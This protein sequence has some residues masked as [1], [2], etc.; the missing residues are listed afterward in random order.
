MPSA[1]ATFPA[2]LRPSALTVRVEKSYPSFSLKLDFQIPEAGIT[3]VF[4]PSG[5]GKTTL[6]NLVAGLERPDRGL[7]RHHERTLFDS[8]SGV[9]L[10]PERRRLGYV[11]Q[12]PLLF[13]HLTV[14]GNLRFAPRF[15]GRRGRP[16]DYDK[17]VEL[18][19]L[20]RLLGR[21]PQTLSGGESQRVAIGRALMADP[22]LLL[23]DEPLSSLD[24][25]RKDELVAHIDQ[26]PPRFGLSVLY[27]THDAAEAR[28]LADNVLPLVDGRLG[29]ETAFQPL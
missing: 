12:S 4:G 17:V 16:G 9:C 21:R 26:I 10:P 25:G 20:G 15:C 2:Q 18:L 19:G 11:F 24:Q 3:V 14:A 23:M 13:S 29:P 7:I 28:A 27:V 1:P 8:A 5:A 22:E 6:L